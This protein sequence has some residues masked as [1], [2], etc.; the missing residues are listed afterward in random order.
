MKSE[1][2]SKLLSY[3]RRLKSSKTETIQRITSAIS[4]DINVYLLKPPIKRYNEW[5]LVHEANIKCPL[6]GKNKAELFGPAH[7]WHSTEMICF[8]CGLS[9]QNWRPGKLLISEIKE[10]WKEINNL[11]LKQIIQFGYWSHK[12]K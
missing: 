9:T 8:N 6:C 7:Y 3:V 4:G 10:Q 1:I 5:L 11:T 12:D 2:K